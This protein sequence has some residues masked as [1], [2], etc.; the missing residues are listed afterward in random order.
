[1]KTIAIHQPNFLPWLGFFE[2]VKRADVFVVLD[3]VPF[4][5]GSYT[6]RVKYLCKSSHKKKW[7][8]IP[9]KYASLGTPINEILVSESTQWSKKLISTIQQNFD[10]PFTEIIVDTIK[11]RRSESLSELN[12]ALLKQLFVAM[13]IDVPMVK[14]SQ[15][16]LDDS[17]E[18]EV[19]KICKSMDAEVYLSGIGGRNYIDNG[20]FAQ[21]GI[22]VDFVDFYKE[23]SEMPDVNSDWLG[24]SA[25]HSI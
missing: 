21:K 9:T 3:H 19:L 6:N 7:L 15:L 16:A 14:S 2:K 1:M 24:L 5:K 10:S 8:T 18:Q 4:S 13:N 22:R 12:I 17:G 20:A 25:L 11:N 23:L